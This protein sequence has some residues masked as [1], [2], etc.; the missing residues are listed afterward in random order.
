MR[1]GGFFW[2]YPSPGRTAIKGV[3]K[4]L[5]LN[6]LAV[7]ALYANQERIG[8]R[9]FAQWKD[10]GSFKHRWME[11]VQRAGLSGLVFHDIRRTFATWLTQ[12]GVDY[13][14]IRMLRGE[15][16]PGSAKYY[17]QNWDTPLRDAVTKLE[18]Y[19]RRILEGDS[20]VQVPPL[21]ASQVPPSYLEQSL[22]P[23]KVVPRDRIELSTPA[24]SGLCSAN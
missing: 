6:A 7:E 19:T 8:G 11:T 12:S 5:P 24:F 18:A 22:S 17:I 21:T 23:R 1:T 20:A 13:A 2:L 4:A 10:A 16:L 15:P 14:I 9:F 3:P